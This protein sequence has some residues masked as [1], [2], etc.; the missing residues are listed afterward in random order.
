[1]IGVHTNRNAPHVDDMHIYAA[2]HR[3]THADHRPY[4]ELEASMP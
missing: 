1:M 3:V 4:M 2:A